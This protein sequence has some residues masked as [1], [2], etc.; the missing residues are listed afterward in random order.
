LLVGVRALGATEGGAVHLL[1]AAA[2]LDRI[3]A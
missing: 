1:F 2:D 3:A